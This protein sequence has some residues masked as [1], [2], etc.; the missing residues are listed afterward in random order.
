MT[1]LETQLIALLQ[2]SETESKQRET[3][4]LEQVSGLQVTVSNLQQRLNSLTPALEQLSKQQHKVMS[5]YNEI[6]E[7]LAKE[8]QPLEATERTNSKG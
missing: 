4:F 2:A 5:Q 8:W 1:E 7:L 6:S 3:H